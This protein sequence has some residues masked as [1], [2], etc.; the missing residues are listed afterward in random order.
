MHPKRPL[1]QLRVVS[2]VVGVVLERARRVRQIEGMWVRQYDIDTEITQTSHD[3]AVEGGDRLHRQ[4]D[5][6]L[7]ATIGRYPQHM[8]EKVEGAGEYR[9]VASRTERDR[10]PAARSEPIGHMPP[11]VA[12][13]AL[14]KGNL[15]DDLGEPV[16][17]LLGGAPGF[18]R[19]GG[20]RLDSVHIETVR[21]IE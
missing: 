16:Q 11:V 2:G 9:S 17:C 3:V 7:D 15:A 18:Q 13:D 5:L 10:G 1:R 19:Q 6:D 21:P 4:I 8:I 12:P 20:Q 14:G